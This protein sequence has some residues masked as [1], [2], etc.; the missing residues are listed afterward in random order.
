MNFRT[1]PL[2][3]LAACSLLGLLAPGCSKSEKPAAVAQPAVQRVAPSVPV[4]PVAK[5]TVPRVSVPF[6]A[7]QASASW[8]SIK[9]YTFDQRSDF[10]AG[11]AVME[12]S[13]ASQVAELNTKRAALPPSVDT[14]EWDFAM[15]NLMDAQS[16]LKSTVDEA[17]RT[18]P[19]FWNQEKDKV[20]QAWQKAEENFDAV[21]TATTF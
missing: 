11:A 20:D 5:P 7:D 14:K 8:A 4:Q 19:E 18:S 21:R 2:R 10:A 1:I 13:L 17:G 6:Q 3:G 12:A 16:Y 15:R 9:D